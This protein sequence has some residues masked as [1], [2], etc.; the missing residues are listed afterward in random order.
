MKEVGFVQTKGRGVRPHK[1]GSKAPAPPCYVS[2]SILSINFGKM[3]GKY[4]TILYKTIVDKIALNF[5]LF[6]RD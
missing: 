3:F 2:G 6:L 5:G 4:S 1:R